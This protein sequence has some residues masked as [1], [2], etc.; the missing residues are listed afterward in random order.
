MVSWPLNLKKMVFSTAVT[1]LIN[2]KISCMKIFTLHILYYG[3]FYPSQTKTVLWGL[4]SKLQSATQSLRAHWRRQLLRLTD[5]G[6]LWQT[7]NLT[8]T[9]FSLLNLKELRKS[10]FCK[11]KCPWTPFYFS[12]YFWKTVYKSVISNQA[13]QTSSFYIFAYLPLTFSPAAV[14]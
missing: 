2:N 10:L 12:H 3:Q 5:T 6:W 7:W 9:I 11:I 14:L 8:R 4:C 1:P 13:C